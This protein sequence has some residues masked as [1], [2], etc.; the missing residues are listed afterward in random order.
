MDGTLYGYGQLQEL[1]LHMLTLEGRCGTLVYRFFRGIHCTRLEPDR[2]PTLGTPIPTT[3]LTH[4]YAPQ[5]HYRIC[6]SSNP[7]Y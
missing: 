1:P 3:K 6:N 5:A 7:T 4:A 2:S